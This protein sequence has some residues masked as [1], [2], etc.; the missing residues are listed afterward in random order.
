MT[1]G[2]ENIIKEKNSIIINLNNEIQE[3]KYKIEEVLKIIME[4]A[5]IF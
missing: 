4:K 2:L 1:V 5:E 3:Y